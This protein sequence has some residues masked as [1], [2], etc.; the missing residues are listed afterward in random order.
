[1]LSTKFSG[2]VALLFAGAALL[3]GPAS[4]APRTATSKGATPPRAEFRAL[5][6]D[7]YHEGIRNEE[8]AER[9]VN[10]ARQAN[11]NALFVQVRG[12][13]DALYTQTQEPAY[14]SESY[15]PNFDALENI[16]KLAHRERIEVY[17]WLN[18]T[19]EWHPRGAPKDSRHIF[20]SHGPAQT[21]VDDWLTRSPEGEARFPL[22]F[23]LDPGN[24]AAA[25]Y[26]AGIF[27]NIVRRYAIDGIHFD[28]MRY[29]ESAKPLKRGSAV[30]Y[31]SISLDRFRRL[32]RR[33]DTP[34]PDD[35]QWSDWRRRQV[36]QLVRRIYIESK[37]I[38]RQIKVSA[39][40]IA[41]DKPPTSEKDFDETQAS[42]WLYQDWHDW[43]KE[44]ILDIVVPMN[45]ARENQPARR[46][47]FDGWIHWEKRHKHGRA[48][49]IGIGA[50]LNP[51]DATLAQIGRA[52]AID[53][54]HQADGVSLFS[55]AALAA[56]RPRVRGASTPA[57]MV[58]KL[59][60]NQEGEIRD[61][62]VS[63][64]SNGA[65]PQP[66]AFPEVVS[67]PEMKRIDHPKQ[68]WLDGTV[69]NSGGVAVDGAIVT[70]RRVGLFSRRKRSEADGN[71]YFGFTQMRPGRYHVRV[72]AGPKKTGELSVRV[73]AG[74]VSKVELIQPN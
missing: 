7:E 71:G 26:I 58:A 68:G 34:A 40:V 66:P 44:G 52:R 12:H 17:A 43:L 15:D 51:Q 24:P 45:Y 69:Q 60:P 32:Q 55:Y 27:L 2:F 67:L 49:I 18:A 39:A 14:E 42:G 16:I 64:L 22:G 72:E 5:W 57:A 46:E 38:N 35:P 48:L 41:W 11:I 21:G 20:N 70:A 50:Y 47:W 25:D 28:F 56:R 37:E 59:D 1:M 62:R 74:R 54:R 61:E 6:V 8:E 31:N 23:F 63:F 73:V 3:N 30:G 19:T 36:T 29:P 13:A 4:A 9:L 53:G 65:P 10:A 33:Q